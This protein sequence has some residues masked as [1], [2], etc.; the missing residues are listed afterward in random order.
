MEHLAM[1]MERVMQNVRDFPCNPANLAFTVQ[2]TAKD[3]K[4][5]AGPTADNMADK[6]KQ[7]GKQAA[8][9]AKD[10]A[11]QARKSAHS[12]LKGT[13]FLTMPLAILKS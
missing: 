1:G 13:P 4:K 12:A 7:G 9:Q 3:V 8:E 5:N 6:A 2:D 11:G 10:G